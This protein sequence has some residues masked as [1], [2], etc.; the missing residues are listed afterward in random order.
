MCLQWAL[1]Q[2]LVFDKIKGR[3][4]GQ[5]RYALTGGAAL[6]PEVQTFLGDIGIPVVEVCLP[7]SL[8]SLPGRV[9]WF[10]SRPVFLG[11]LL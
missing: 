2:R 10:S 1:A 8:N 11:F 6:S 7:S 4:G 5:L 9:L 3:F